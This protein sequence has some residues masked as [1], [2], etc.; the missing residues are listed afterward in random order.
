MVRKIDA[1]ARSLLNQA[2]VEAKEA[3]TDSGF[4]NH[5]YNKIILYVRTYKDTDDL[6]ELLGYS[7]YTAESGTPAEKKQILDRW[8]QAP[9]TPY[10]IT[11]TA[12]AEGFDYP[13]IRLVINIDDPESLVIFA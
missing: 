13:Y 4:F 11:T 6:A 5:A 10:I 3:W 2:I 12:L 7:S 1:C 8:I 9:N